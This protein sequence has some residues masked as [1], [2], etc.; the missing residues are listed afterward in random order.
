[1]GLPSASEEPD[2]FRVTVLPVIA[3]WSGPALAKGAELSV[4]ITTVSGVLER[5]PS[6]TTSVTV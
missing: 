1:M 6:L 5:L 4:E 3:V 2:P